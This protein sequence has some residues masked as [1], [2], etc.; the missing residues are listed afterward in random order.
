MGIRCELE[1]FAILPIFVCDLCNEQ[2]VDFRQATAI[3]DFGELDKPVFLHNVCIPED[4]T[5]KEYAFIGLVEFM[6]KL[7]MN[8]GVRNENIIWLGAERNMYR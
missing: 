6:R 1:G 2:I 8:I 5:P 7:L 4:I 3:V